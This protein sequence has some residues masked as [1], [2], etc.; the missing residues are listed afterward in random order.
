[1][2]RKSRR[3]KKGSVSIT[4]RNG[5]IRLRWT[6]RGIPYQL[7]LG[8]PDSPLNHQLATAVAAEIQSDI[9]RERFDTTLERY[10]PKAA[11]IAPDPAPLTT[12]ALFHQY[13]ETRR[14]AGTSGQALAARYLPLANNL[15]RWGNINS[16]E[17]ARGF[18]STLRRRQAP[19]TAN[20]NL[21]ALKG[22]GRWAVEHGHWPTN[23]FEPI[24]RLKDS[25]PSN[26]KRQPFTADQIRAVLSFL[27]S[28]PTYAHW[29]SFVMALFYLGLRPSEA[30]ALRWKH[31]DLER[32]QVTVAESLSRAEDGNS[33]SCR[34]QRKAT[35]TGKIRVV[36]IHPTWPPSS[37]AGRPQ[38]PNQTT[39]FSLAPRATRSASTISVATHGNESAK[40]LA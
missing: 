9:A 16:T 2:S 3:T 20:Q 22:F 35:K 38:G 21:S 29:H 34:R 14:Q 37:P 5:M 8:L 31:I 1:M 24:P 23:W 17:D 39:W 7:S 19:M 12:V 11:P 33:A 28:D 4:T 25:Q 15:Q 13:T 30:A 36:G 10:R 40:P 32:R 18:V 6:H 26:P 27:E